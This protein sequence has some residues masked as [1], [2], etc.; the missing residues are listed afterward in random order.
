MVVVLQVVQG[1]RLLLVL[2]LL[3]LGYFLHLR[4][5][6]TTYHIPSTGMKKGHA[7]LSGCNLKFHRSILLT[8]HWLELVTDT[9]HP[10]ERKGGQCAGFIR[11]ASCVQHKKKSVFYCYE[12]EMEIRCWASTRMPSIGALSLK[13]GWIFQLIFYIIQNQWLEFFCLNEQ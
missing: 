7:F 4:W 11:Y 3:P 8:L 6:V 13:E 2:F 5:L 12:K 9:D 10:T 1:P